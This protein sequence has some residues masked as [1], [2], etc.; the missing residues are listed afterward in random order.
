M[1]RRLSCQREGEILLPSSLYQILPLFYIKKWFSLF[2][3]TQLKKMFSYKASL[4]ILKSNHQGRV[5]TSIKFLIVTS[6]SRRSLSLG[7]KEMTFLLRIKVLTPSLSFLKRHRQI[8]LWSKVR[9]FISS[10]KGEDSDTT[11]ELSCFIN[12]IYLV[13][14]FFFLLCSL[15][16]PRQ[17]RCW[18]INGVKEPFWL[19]FYRYRF[20]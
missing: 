18:I 12:M 16:T 6:F 15:R 3:S 20:P 14:K 4:K 9:N 7:T 10:H 5:F 2:Q 19:G 17:D 8:F 13:N 1:K 11:K